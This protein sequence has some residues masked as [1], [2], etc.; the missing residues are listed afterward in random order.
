M[1][2]PPAVIIHG[3][4]HALSVLAAGRPA[5]LLSAPGAAC[6]AGCGWWRAVVTAALAGYPGAAAPDVLD[7]D[8]AP[9]RALEALSVGC[10][11]IVLQ[12]GPAWRD[13]A[14]RAESCGARL[15]AAAPP[16]LDMGRRGEDRRLAAW[17]GA[18]AGSPCANAAHP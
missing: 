15:L 8:D 17:L 6:Y 12:P 14:A 18:S 4:P 13:I 2:L 16:A 3:L 11:L 10:R 7:C 1:T 9:G 5:T